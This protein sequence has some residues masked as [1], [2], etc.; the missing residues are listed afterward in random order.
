MHES[1]ASRLKF[2][3][4]YNLLNQV[5]LLFSQVEIRIS[6]PLYLCK[7]KLNHISMKTLR[8]KAYELLLG[9]NVNIHQITFHNN[10]KR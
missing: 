6:S 3:D 7:Y 5:K 4:H 1:I 10:L 2:E 8:D 9:I